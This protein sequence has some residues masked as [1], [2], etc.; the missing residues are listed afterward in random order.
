M[1]C[2]HNNVT[3]N[4]QAHRIHGGLTLASFINSHFVGSDKGK[5]LSHSEAWLYNC[6]E[7]P[8]KIDLYCKLAWI[9]NDDEEEKRGDA[10]REHWKGRKYHEH[11]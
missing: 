6:L 9:I 11:F 4:Y 2:D 10:S 8:T 1:M 7:M 3:I 5:H